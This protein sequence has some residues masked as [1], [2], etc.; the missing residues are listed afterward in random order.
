MDHAGNLYLSDVGN[1][2]I[3][4][5]DA[6]TG[7]ITTIAGNGTAGFSGDG[8]PATSAQL[9]NPDQIA[10]DHAGNVYIADHNNSC[11]RAVSAATGIIATIANNATAG[12]SL[13]NGVA[14]DRSDNLYVAN[15]NKNQILKI[16]AGS[17]TVTTIAGTGTA[18]TSGDGGPATSAQLNRPGTL[19]F[20][21]SGT[22]T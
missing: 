20:D 18:G 22:C 19:A 15:T 12:I 11:I 14:L 6:N 13:P 1:N 8:G 17:G 3:R 5:I 16:A 21:A 2:V 4:R 7:V 9:S 10:L